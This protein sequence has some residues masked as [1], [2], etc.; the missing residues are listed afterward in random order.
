MS[1]IKDL[2]S[3]TGN[4]MDIDIHKLLMKKAGTLLAR[5]AYSRADL[6][7]RLA[8]F[9]GGEQVEAVLRHLERLKLLNDAD[10][11]YTFA[12]RRIRRLGWSSAK[13]QNAL[14]GHQVDPMIIDRA[15]EQVR[16]ECGGEDSVIR[17]YLRKRY[18]K[19][20]LPVDCKGIRKLILH[21]RQRGFEEETIFSAL[22]GEIPDAALRRFRTGEYID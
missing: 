6:Q 22:K 12:F 14:L 4:L 18:E 10:Y 8:A 1:G 3:G 5:R 13:V 21:L 11:A 9:G 19:G 2:K 15:L 20:G 16:N 7:K 17:E